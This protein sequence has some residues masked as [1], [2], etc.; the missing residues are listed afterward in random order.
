[1]SETQTS[2]SAQ[3]VAAAA[4]STTVTDAI[5]RSLEV[6]RLIVSERLRFLKAVPAELQANPLWLTT[7]LTVASV[8]TMDGVPCPMPINEAA[9]ERAGDRLGD[10]GMEAVQAALETLM[11]KPQTPKEAL[12]TAGE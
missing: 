11:M 5:G 7:A 2:P 9:I 4:R 1:M 8:A 3:I 6:K 10:E 12:A